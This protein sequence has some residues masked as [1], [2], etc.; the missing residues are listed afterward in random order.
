[1]AFAASP[2]LRALLQE[3]VDARLD[4]PELFTRAGKLLP[5]GSDPAE[6]ILELLAESDLKLRLSAG[7]DAFVRRL[8]QFAEARETIKGLLRRFPS[9][10]LVKPARD[11]YQSTLGRH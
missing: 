6:E 4:A 2:E 7:R 11:L 10:P 1:M 5:A 3:F 9:S 8:E